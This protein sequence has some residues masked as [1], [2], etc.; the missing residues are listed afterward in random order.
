LEGVHY[1]TQRQKKRNGKDEKVAEVKHVHE[2]R[3]C[4]IPAVYVEE[5]MYMEMAL[6]G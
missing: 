4:V 1:W 6:P 2:E 5:D 3:S